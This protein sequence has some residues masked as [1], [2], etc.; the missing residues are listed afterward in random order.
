MT[1]IFKQALQKKPKPPDYMEVHTV[2]VFCFTGDHNFEKNYY[3]PWEL[4]KNNY[5]AAH[6]CNIKN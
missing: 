6:E 2:A 5:Y 4:K 1:S 3:N